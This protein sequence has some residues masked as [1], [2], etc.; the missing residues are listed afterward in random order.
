MELQHIHWNG[1]DVPGEGALR[2]ALE[3]EGF[4]VTP[5]RDPSDRTYE[6]HSHPNDESLWIVR[7]G[8]VLHIGARDFPLGP[9]DRLML[10][11]GVV[12]SAQAG[13]E[14]ATYLIGHRHE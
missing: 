13:P 6:A 14:G 8:I 10:P 12:H 2:T 9:G 1:D 5:W 3:A 11:R 4:E 7:G